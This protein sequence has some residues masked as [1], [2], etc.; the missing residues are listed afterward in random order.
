MDLKSDS[1]H[2]EAKLTEIMVALWTPTRDN[3]LLLKRW[4]L[5]VIIK[6]RN[7]EITQ[8]MT[9]DYKMLEIIILLVSQWK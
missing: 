6:K 4:Y 3:G 8:I 5:E 1:A 2:I 7:G 9:Q